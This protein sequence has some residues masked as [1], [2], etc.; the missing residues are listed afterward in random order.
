[1]LFLNAPVQTNTNK[2]FIAIQQLA[3]GG[4]LVVDSK[5]NIYSNA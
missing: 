1:M 5:N 4:T 2:G 3:E